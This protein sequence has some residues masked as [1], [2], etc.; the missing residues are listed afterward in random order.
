MRRAG[1]PPAELSTDW[2]FEHALTIAGI[3]L[4]GVFGRGFIHWAI[5]EAIG[6]DIGWQHPGA[7]LGTVV[8]YTSLLTALL[9]AVA[10]GVSFALD[11]R[12]VD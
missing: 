12:N 4:V 11:A 3:L 8:F 10:V 7:S 6:L 1:V 5:D 9:Y 2:L